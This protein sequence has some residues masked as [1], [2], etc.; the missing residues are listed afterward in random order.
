MQWNKSAMNELTKI[1]IAALRHSSLWANVEIDIIVN[2]VPVVKA[3]TAESKVKCAFTFGNGF[4]VEAN[5]RLKEYIDTLPISEL[6]CNVFL[7]WNRINGQILS[8]FL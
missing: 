8:T 4:Y 1:V 6:S 5:K 3:V 7:V 2:L